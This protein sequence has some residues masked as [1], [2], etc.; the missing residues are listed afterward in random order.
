MPA[1]RYTSRVFAMGSALYTKLSAVSIDPHPNT[2]VTPPVWFSDEDPGSA[3]EYV[4]V[5]LNEDGSQIE[6]Q[7]LG[8]AGRDETVAVDVVFRTLTEWGE[9]SDVWDRLEHVADKIQ[10][11][12]YDTV[13]EQ[14]VNLDFDGEQWSQVVSVQPFVWPVTGGWNGAV[15]ITFQSY[16]TI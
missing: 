1:G 3:N 4:T 16:C 15:R 2:A 11:V 14:V 6:F 12:V 5:A 13:N 8:P 7:R 9:S 10:S